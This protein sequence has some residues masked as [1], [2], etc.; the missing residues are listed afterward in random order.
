[1]TL[2]R[3][4][5]KMIDLGSQPGPLTAQ[6]TSP[7]VAQARVPWRDLAR[8]TYGAVAQL[9]AFGGG[10]GGVEFSEPF[11]YVWQDRV[12]VNPAHEQPKLIF[13]SGAQPLIRWGLNRRYVM[14][15]MTASPRFR[16]RWAYVGF[17]L[18]QYTERPRITGVATRRGTTYILPRVGTGPGPRGIPL[19]GA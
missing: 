1:M 2:K 10:Q 14:T 15:H 19:G 11:S 13:N 8:Q 6:Q 18:R 17:I 7:G 12:Q 3:P 16:G 9:K 4:P 5:A